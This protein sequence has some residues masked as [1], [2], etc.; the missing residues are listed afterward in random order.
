[1]LRMRLALLDA[2]AGRLPEGL[3]F[4]MSADEVEVALGHTA[5]R[6]VRNGVV[7]ILKHGDVEF[8]FG[9]VGLWMIIRV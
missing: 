7:G 9:P 3:R 4:G 5:A 1:M 6:N 2:L 8:H